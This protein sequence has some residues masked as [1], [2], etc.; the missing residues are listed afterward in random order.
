[1]KEVTEPYEALE[2]ENKRLKQ[3]S[4]HLKKDK[5]QL[6]KDKNQLQLLRDHRFRMNSEA[7]CIMHS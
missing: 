4:H 1:M 6:Q 7:V 3:E 5:E 2:K